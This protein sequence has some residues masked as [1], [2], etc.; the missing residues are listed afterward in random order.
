MTITQIENNITK[1]FK[2]FS[3][4]TFVF[5]YSLRMVKHKLQL[6]DFK[7]GELK[8]LET[9]CELL[10]RKKLLFKE[11]TAHL[12]G[13]IDTLRNDSATQKNLDLF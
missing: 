3:A 2:E 1:L 13:T 8:Q 9:K 12:H 11:A 5:D 6:L 4:D 10:L 7:K